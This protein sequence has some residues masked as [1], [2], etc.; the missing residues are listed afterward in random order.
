MLRDESEIYYGIEG[1]RHGPV[2]FARLCS[3]LENGRVGVEDYIWNAQDDRWVQISEFEELRPHL[4]EQFLQDHGATPP[5]S[6]AYGYE[7]RDE[8][9]FAG[10]W[11]RAGAHLI[12]SFILTLPFLA[13]MIFLTQFLSIDPESIDSEALLADPFSSSNREM[14]EEMLRF[15]AWMYG[16][17]AI[18]EWIYRAGCESSPWQAT[19]G[20]RAL[21]LF[22][23]DNHGY[24]LSFFRASARHWAKL[25]SQLPMNLGFFIIA[26]SKNKQGFHDML[27]STYVLHRRQ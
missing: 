2:D 1:E 11:V 17:L 3:L 10:F 18:M 14:T 20:K 21:G 5:S 19:I 22:V 23:T 26:V 4:P 8:A 12:D 16:G 15:Q 7:A 9:M 24:R 13:W 6:S 27:A 25:F